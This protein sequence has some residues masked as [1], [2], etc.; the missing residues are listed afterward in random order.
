MPNT[1]PNKPLCTRC[2]TR[3]GQA[4]YKGLCNKCYRE[5]RDVRVPRLPA[6]FGDL[7]EQL[8]D[9]DKSKD[10][11]KNLALQLQPTVVG[12]ADGSIKATAAQAAIIKEILGRA[13]GNV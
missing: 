10:Y 2:K 13:H 1:N 5:T 12:L 9:P 11:W 7:A 6:Q 8:K 4:K 3:N